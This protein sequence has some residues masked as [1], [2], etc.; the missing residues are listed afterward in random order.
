MNLVKGQ[1]YH[2]IGGV[3][4]YSFDKLSLIAGIPVYM[5]TRP[6]LAAFAPDSDVKYTPGSTKHF[7]HV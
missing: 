2:V 4:Y 7:F 5:Y 3:Q 6:I 1:R